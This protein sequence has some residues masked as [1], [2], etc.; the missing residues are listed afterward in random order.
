[1]RASALSGRS[2]VPAPVG[3]PLSWARLGWA[4]GWLV[5]AVLCVAAT[6]AVVAPGWLDGPTRELPDRL[7]LIADIFFNNLL[8]ALVPLLGGWLAAGHLL[9]GRRAVASIFVVLPTLMVARSVLTIG[10]VGGSDAAWLADA[11]RWWLL[12]LAALAAASATGLWLVRNPELRER[13][14]PPAMR[15]AL[16]IVLATLATGA[17]IEVLTA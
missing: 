3:A 11:A 5:A 15:R 6:I 16:A 12:E 7:S 4:W 2:P 1:M 10:A 14:G 9:A 8:Q 17:I 13:F